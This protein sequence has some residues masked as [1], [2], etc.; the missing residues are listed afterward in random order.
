VKVRQERAV[1]ADRKNAI[2]IKNCCGKLCMSCAYLS[3]I[4]AEADYSDNSVKKFSDAKQRCGFN[5]KGEESSINPREGFRLNSIP[6]VHFGEF[7]VQTKLFLKLLMRDCRPK[8]FSINHS[9]TSQSFTRPMR[10]YREL[11]RFM[12]GRLVVN[13]TDGR[14]DAGCEF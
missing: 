13:K 12:V 14:K 11:L 5:Y 4:P 6:P 3:G 1:S 10:I 7:I 8:C 9:G 2:L